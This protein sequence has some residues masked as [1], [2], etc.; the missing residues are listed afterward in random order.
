MSCET[1]LPNLPGEDTH[2]STVEMAWY[3]MTPLTS[4]K[5]MLDLMT[6]Q[7]STL[8]Y[9]CLLVSC[10]NYT[11]EAGTQISWANRF[12]QYQPDNG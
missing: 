1:L 12:R 4:S 6:N 3:Y 7:A 11:Y 10:P 2:I 9:P 8:T 5:D